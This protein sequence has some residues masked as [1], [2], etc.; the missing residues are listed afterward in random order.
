M[1]YVIENPV[2]KTSYR[3]VL[4]NKK[5]GKPTLQGWAIVENAGEEDWKDV[6]VALVS[7]RPISFKMDL[8]QPLFVPRPTVEPELFA[9]LRPPTYAGAME[10]QKDKQQ[11]AR[12][13]AEDLR[14]GRLRLAQDHD[15]AHQR[16]GGQGVGEGHQRRVEQLRDPADH[17]EADERR[18]RED[19]EVGD[20][21]VR[22]HE[23][24]PEHN[25]AYHRLLEE[26]ESL[27]G[28]GIVL[29]TSFNLHGDPIVYRARDAVDVFLRSGLEHMALGSFWVE[30]R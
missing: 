30:K 16:D 4:S 25:P 20:D 22:A 19:E 18:Q 7:G 14:V 13:E 29:N 1:A 6:R 15:R 11:A 3:L 2:W 23:V 17:L 8:Y 5:D 27:T 10:R 9:S 12:D 21:Q 24:T 26:Y 28:E